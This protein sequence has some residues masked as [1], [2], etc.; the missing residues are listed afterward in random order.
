MNKDY[1]LYDFT[2]GLFV[3][4]LIISN[5]AST[6]IVSVGPFT[7]D[8][9]TILFP[10]AYI[11]GD[12][13]T[14]VYGFRR[15]RRTIWIGFASLILMSGVFWII[16][17]MAPAPGWEMQNAYE[18]ILMATPRIA[19][20]SIIGYWAGSF[21][22]SIILSKMKVLTKGKHLWTRTIGSTLVGELVDTLLFC[23]VAFGG[24]LSNSLLLS[25]IISNYVFKVSYEILATPI[26]YKVIDIYKKS[27][28]EDAYD[29]ECRVFSL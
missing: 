22:N 16:G 29:E 8:G 6:K 9:G 5:I 14:E 13:L 20:A 3:A 2:V 26:T 1:K 15:A 7:F 10:I 21:S 24:I 25:V 4:V 27:E 23:I 17:K 18:N 28:N 19:I 11:F 12:V